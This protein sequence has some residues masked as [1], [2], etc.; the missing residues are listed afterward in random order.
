MV[1]NLWH[2]LLFV[3]LTRE[4]IYIQIY[5]KSLYLQRHKYETLGAKRQL[6]VM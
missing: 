3:T 4:K 6:W 1:K 5:I 2:K